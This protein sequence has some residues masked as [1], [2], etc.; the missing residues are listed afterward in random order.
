[1]DNQVHG[2]GN[3]NFQIG[4][5]LLPDSLDVD[6]VLASHDNGLELVNWSP[7]SNVDGVRLW[8]KH[9]APLTYAGGIQVPRSLS[10]SFIINLLNPSRFGW[11]K[12][13]LESNG[14][15]MIITNKTSEAR[16][17]FSIPRK[18]PTRSPLKCS[19]PQPEDSMINA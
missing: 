15:K 17:V 7:T 2:P 18:F 8:A 16:I 1:L 12:S 6:L 3:G 11:D 13:L 5:A 4:L 10:D 9:F 19:T 14:W